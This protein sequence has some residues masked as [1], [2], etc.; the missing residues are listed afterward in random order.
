MGN[1]TLLAIDQ[2]TT[3]SR[4]ILFSQA[5]EV[6][7]IQ[8]KELPLYYPQKGWVEQRPD[9]MWNDVRDCCTKMLNQAAQ[10]PVAIGITNQ[11]ENNHCLGSKNRRVSFITRLSGKT[12][13]R[14][15]YARS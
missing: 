3:S 12:D 14:Q 6:L 4:A 1:P 7:D 15:S 5:G 10:R 11:R 13:A 8:Q 2:G 9:D